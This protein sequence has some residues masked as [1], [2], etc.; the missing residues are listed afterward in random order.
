M[1]KKNAAT[2]SLDVSNF[3]VQE[4]PINPNEAAS[5]VP[6]AGQVITRSANKVTEY[7][8]KAVSAECLA[9]VGFY[10]IATSFADEPEEGQNEPLLHP[11]HVPMTIKADGD[12]HEYDVI[13]ITETREQREARPIFRNGKGVVS[14]NAQGEFKVALAE[15][16]NLPL[17]S[18]GK[19]LGALWT[20]LSQRI[21]P[22][23]RECIVESLEPSVVMGKL[24][25]APMDG[26]T[27]SA[28]GQA[29]IEGAEKS[30]AEARKVAGL[31]S[32]GTPSERSDSS[33]SSDSAPIVATRSE[34]LSLIA[35]D[36]EAIENGDAPALNVEEIRKLDFVR[37]A[38]ARL[39]NKGYFELDVLEI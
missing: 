10:G 4:T 38:T 29:I 31:N 22:M 25:L 2:V 27:P 23:V 36:L 26:T 32:K 3:D 16:Y 5:F 17:Q 14:K 20:A 13:P 21:L 33:D 1:S 11:W 7:K 39:Y 37:K 34:L 18:N 28:R 30:F 12:V 35:S 9:V 19:M 15:R 8:G 24:V 6:M